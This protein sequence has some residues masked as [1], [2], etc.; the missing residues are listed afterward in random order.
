MTTDDGIK[1]CPSVDA[2]GVNTDASVIGEYGWLSTADVKYTIVTSAVGSSAYTDCTTL[3]YLRARSD[4]SLIGSAVENAAFDGKTYTVQPK[5]SDPQHVFGWVGKQSGWVLSKPTEQCVN[6]TG[7]NGKTLNQRLFGDISRCPA[8]YY[9]PAAKVLAGMGLISTSDCTATSSL[10]GQLGAVEC[11]LGSFALVGDEGYQAGYN[12]SD[13]YVNCIVI[14]GKTTTKA[15]AGK[16]T[17]VKGCDNAAGVATWKTTTWDA[18]TNTISNLCAID[19]CA[20]GYVM[21]GNACKRIVTLTLDANGGSTPAVTKVYMISYGEDAYEGFFKDYALT[22]HVTC[23]DLKSERTGYTF[24]A[25][26][27]LMYVSAAGSCEFDTNEFFKNEDDMTISATW[28][29]NE[30]T[31]TFNA[32][33]GTGGP[34]TATVVYDATMAKLTSLPTRAGYQFAGYYDAA[35][36]GTMYYGADGTAARKWDKAANTTLYAQWVV[37]GEYRIGY[38]LYGGTNAASNPGTYTVE[39]E[40]ITLADPTRTGYTFGGWYSESTFAT[41]V[42]QIAKGSTGNKMLYAKWAPIKYTIKY[43]ANGGTGTV[44]DTVCTYDADCTI[45]ANGFT[46]GTKRFVAWSMDAAGYSGVYTA[47]Q[48]LK[49]LSASA[50]TIN[51]YAFWGTCTACAAGAGANCELTAPLGVCRYATSCRTGY[52]TPVNAGKYNPTCSVITYKITYNLN[53]GTNPADAKTQYTVETADYTL[54]TPTKKGY[55]FGGWF[56]N[57]AFTGG[58]VTK[59]ARGSTGAKTF[60]A[61]FTPMKIY[62]NPGKYLV[63]GAT[64]CDAVCP[65]GSMCAGGEVTYTGTEQGRSVC[66]AGTFSQAGANTCTKCLSGAFSATDG[67]TACTPCAAGTTNDGWG[68]TKC[69]IQCANGAHVAKWM[70]ST[71]SI[72]NG[73]MGQVVAGECEIESCATGYLLGDNECVERI[74]CVPGKYYDGTRLVPCPAGSYCPGGGETTPGVPSCATSCATVGDGSYNVSVP[75]ASSAAGCT[76]KCDA[77]PIAGGVAKPVLEYAPYPTQCEFT[78]VSDTGNPCDIIDGR[79]V[80]TRCNGNYELINGRCEP[81]GR[82]FALSYNMTAGNCIVTK[83]EIGYHPVGDGCAEN[84]RECTIPGAI[85]AAQEWNDKTN[86]FG[87]CTVTECDDGYHIASNKCV[88][89]TQACTVANGTGTQEW[90]HVSNTWGACVATECAAGYTNEKTESA[91]PTRECGP[92]RNGYGVDGTRVA[93]SYIR[94]CEIASCMYQG[95]MYNLENNECVPICSVAGYSDETGTMKWNPVTKKCDRTCADGYRMW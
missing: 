56:T 35:T 37:E 3:A 93:S 94:G 8:G 40:P 92:C 75:G 82:D 57:D 83:C 30:Y 53:G 86:S 45:A 67:A 76:H 17:D 58:A 12:D 7:L 13:M 10:S 46:N 29:A 20:T 5:S 95:E 39:T 16:V 38:E 1:A 79:C 18:E 21:V 4:K 71:W 19:T 11:P 42:T 27:E 51:M 63:T 89:D 55:D 41:R 69:D 15:G 2:V 34:S 52:D 24:L 87:A 50:S 81:C 74:T 66:P 54:P 33:N 73:S 23:D 14:S 59:I 70:Q 88:S 28:R 47:G 36:G 72:G 65:A 62:C 78:G 61:K 32:N 64:V 26:G 43:N 68:N 91:E 48:V 31:I 90:N 25:W 80:E 6:I 60:W 84:T 85:S 49:N 22:Q 77:Y 9:C 44:A